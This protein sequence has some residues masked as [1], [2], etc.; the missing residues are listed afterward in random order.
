MSCDPIQ[1]VLNYWKVLKIN[2]TCFKGIFG[3]NV[4]ST[5]DKKSQTEQKKS[6]DRLKVKRLLNSRLLVTMNQRMLRMVMPVKTGW[7]HTTSSNLQ[8]FTQD[9]QPVLNLQGS[10]TSILQATSLLTNLIRKVR[11]NLIKPQLAVNGFT[12]GSILMNENS[13]EKKTREDISDCI[14]KLNSTSVPNKNYV[15]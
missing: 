7:R 12:L 4:S 13:C 9:G 6:Q 1:A 14:S 10:K 15:M 2:H 3:Y 5:L 8:P 11:Q